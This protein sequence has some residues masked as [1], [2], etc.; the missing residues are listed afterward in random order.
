MVCCYTR[1]T[2]YTANTVRSGRATSQTTSYCHT[3]GEVSEDAIQ[4]HMEYN[5]PGPVKKVSSS[6]FMFLC[7]DF[8]P[9]VMYNMQRVEMISF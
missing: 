3:T 8:T 2:L 1:L 7:L 5:S 4:L 6:S 9:V